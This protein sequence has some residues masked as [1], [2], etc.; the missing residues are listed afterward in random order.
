MHIVGFNWKNVMQKQPYIAIQNFFILLF[1][2]FK[3]HYSA[4]QKYC[5]KILYSSPPMHDK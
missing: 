5:M 2:N 3:C 1:W 4:C